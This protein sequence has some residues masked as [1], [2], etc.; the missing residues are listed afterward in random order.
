[1]SGSTGTDL[2]AVHLTRGGVPG[3][4]V[5]IP[6]RH[7]HSPNELLDPSDLDACAALVAAFARRLAEPPT[8]D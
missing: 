8:A 3:G 6:L 7:M 5:S 1:V 4:V 2:D